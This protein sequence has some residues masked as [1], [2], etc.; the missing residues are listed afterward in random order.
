MVS[1]ADCPRADHFD[2]ARCGD[3]HCGA[4]LTSYDADGE[5]ICETVIGQES[6]ASFIEA[7][8]ACVPPTAA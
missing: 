8:R 5:P 6:I 3:P 4:H 1:R 7:L 2:L